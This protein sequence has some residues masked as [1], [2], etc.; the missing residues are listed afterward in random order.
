M[1]DSLGIL[2]IWWLGTRYDC[3]KGSSLRLPA[4]KNVTQ[5]AGY[6]A[7]KSK[8]FQAGEAKA[9]P[10]LLQGQSLAAFNPG[11]SG[12]LQI[13]ADTGQSWTFPDA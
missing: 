4:M 7:H 1:A 6:T 11:D 12:E 8:E 2:T 5:V 9:T 3:Q 13:L 10:L